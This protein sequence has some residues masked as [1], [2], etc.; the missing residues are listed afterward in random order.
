MELHIK[1]VSK[2]DAQEFI[3]WRYEPPYDVY[4]IIN[5]PTNSDKIREHI[6]YFVDPTINCHVITDTNGDLLGFV[7]FGTD[8]QVPGGNYNAE[9]LDIGMG[10]RPDLT[11]QGQGHAFITA[12]IN[13][14]V[15]TYEPTMLRTTVA[16]FNTRAQR[17]CLRA[18]FTIVD[19]FVATTWTKK[20]FYI[21]TKTV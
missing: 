19:E 13:F 11:G 16:T 14:A 9:A 17:L 10:I 8:G 1:P 21:L 7:T 3:L 20:P 5:D 6:H 12:A 15:K 2:N 4:N 18:G